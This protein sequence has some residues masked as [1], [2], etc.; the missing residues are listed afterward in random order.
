MMV[1]ESQGC[2][3]LDAQISLSDSSLLHPY[4]RLRQHGRVTTNRDQADTA[5]H[6]CLLPIAHCNQCASDFRG[7]NR[8]YSVL[9]VHND[10]SC[11]AYRSCCSPA[12]K[13]KATHTK[14]TSS[15]P[16]PI[17]LCFARVANLPRGRHV[18]CE[19]VIFDLT[20][21]I[22]RKCG[23]VCG[24]TP[25]C[26]GNAAH[27]PCGTKVTVQQK[28]GSSLKHCFQE[29][30]TLHPSSTSG[31]S[32]GITL[33]LCPSFLSSPP[34]VHFSKW[35]PRPTPTA[36]FARSLQAKSLRSSCTIRTRP[37]LS[38]VSCAT[39]FVSDP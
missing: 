3:K 32:N 19:A 21:L 37:M 17:L 2:R 18:T 24:N 26:P 12:F 11:Q 38:L 7:Q 33:P 29:F 34:P 23:V 15:A 39:R 16:L 8:A 1:I 13:K 10:A 25:P 28:P 9:P 4:N 20:S 6:S 5:A 30:H 27:G 35:Q 36:S 22:S 14:H 31:H